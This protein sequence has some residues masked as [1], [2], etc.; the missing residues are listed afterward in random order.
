MLATDLSDSERKKSNAAHWRLVNVIM[1]HFVFTC[2]QPNTPAVMHST[3][4]EQLRRT[5]R[6]CNI[7]K[8][9]LPKRLTDTDRKK[10]QDL[11]IEAWGPAHRGKQVSPST[12]GFEALKAAAAKLTPNQRKQVL[13]A[14]GN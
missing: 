9:K 12:L 6:Q 5:A 8:L 10:A 13:A 4:T 7:D 3:I 11:I 2:H 1:A 14:M